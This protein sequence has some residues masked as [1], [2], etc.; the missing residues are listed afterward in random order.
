[1]NSDRFGIE[2]KVALIT[3]GSR[4]IGLMIARGFVEAG[5]RVYICA[6]NAQR[7]DAA[8]TDLSQYGDCFSLPADLSTTDE[9][10]RV[11]AILSDKES[12]LHVL[13]NNAGT[14]WGERIDNFPEK[15]WDKV[16]DLNLKSPFFLLQKLLPILETAATKDDP[17]RV[18][19]LGSVDGMHT[20]LYDSY[21]YAAAKAGIHHLTRMLAARLAKRNINVSAIVPGY[22]DTDM[23]QPLIDAY[24]LETLMSIVPLNRIG[25]DAD[26]AGVAIFLASRASRY[27][28]G[29]TLPVDGGITGGC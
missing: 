15:G 2:G 20:P 11:A 12:K 5:A 7:C 17:A 19:N 16:V 13:I 26:I 24:G 8:A 29:I 23:T 10:S 14:A 4:G 6:R 21:S 22:F 27:M 9:V 28:T 18:I 3:G 1:L 25:A